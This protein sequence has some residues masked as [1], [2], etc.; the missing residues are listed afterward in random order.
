MRRGT[1]TGAPG[2]A[3]PAYYL[4]AK[5]RFSARVREMS[6]SSCSATPSPVSAVPARRS[7]GGRWPATLGAMA[8]TEPDTHA[9]VASAYRRFAQFGA[10]GRSPVYE[11]IANAVS[12]DAELLNW[13]AEMP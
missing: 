11:R 6:V 3:E 2:Q 4:P 12:E 1:G 10:A 9:R 5:R 13:L 7:A 8:A